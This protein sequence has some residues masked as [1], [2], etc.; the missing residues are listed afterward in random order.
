MAGQAGWGVKGSGRAAEGSCPAKFGATCWLQRQT[1][2]V[3][4]GQGH[5]KVL[6][7]MGRCSASKAQHPKLL[8]GKKG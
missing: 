2:L 3:S 5:K 4:S 6:G 8:A 1:V 7:I